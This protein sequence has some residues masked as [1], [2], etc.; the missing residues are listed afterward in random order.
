[1]LRCIPLKSL[2]Q[3]WTFSN[4]KSAYP[5]RKKG[6]ARYLKIEKMS[7]Q[8]YLEDGLS[9]KKESLMCSIP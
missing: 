3:P 4:G 6:R 7:S 8:K 1:M 2:E 9:L 5:E